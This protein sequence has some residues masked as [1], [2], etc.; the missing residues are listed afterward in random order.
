MTGYHKLIYLRPL[1][2]V[3]EL[4]SLCIHAQFDKP[5]LL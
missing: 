3:P 2:Y 5:L 1:H 4:S